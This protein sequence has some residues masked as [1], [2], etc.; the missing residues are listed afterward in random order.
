MSTSSV[1]SPEPAAAPRGSV[2]PPARERVYDWLRDR[3]IGGELAG[4]TFLDENW[5]SGTVGVSR[6]PIREAFHQLAAERFIELL[7]RKG[8]QVRTVTGRELAEVYETRRLVE[9]YCA[10]ILC[11]R[12]AGVPAEMAELAEQMSEL[13]MSEDYFLLSGLDRR[14]HR[15]MVAAAG[16]AVLLEVYDSLRSRQQRVAVSAMR[17]KPV[18]IPVINDQHSNLVE[19]LRRN[20][21]PGITAALAEHLRPIPDVLDQLP[22]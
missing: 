2:R 3:I 11:R 17:A 16:N 12:E 7:P 13:G 15:A 5:L 10:E 18:R 1:D 8:A 20:D 22:A 14:F 6:T 4:G 19:L 9:G 21:F